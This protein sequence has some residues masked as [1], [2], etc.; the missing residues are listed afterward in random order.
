VFGTSTHEG[1]PKSSHHSR[2]SNGRRGLTVR[3]PHLQT[4]DP[5]AEALREGHH[6]GETGGSVRHLDGA[7]EEDFGQAI[8]EASLAT[9]NCIKL[10]PAYGGIE[11][12]VM[13]PI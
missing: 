12:S 10:T 11:A 2:H 4:G 3:P 5:H 1:A 6:S 8:M 13:M 9:M 7:G